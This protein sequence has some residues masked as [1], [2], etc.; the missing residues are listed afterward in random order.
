M[1]F[2]L[3]VSV[4]SLTCNKC[5]YGLAGFCLSNSEVTCENQSVCFTA[6][7]SKSPSTCLKAH[8][9]SFQTLHNSTVMIRLKSLP[10][11]VTPSHTHIDQQAHPVFP[12]TKSVSHLT[13]YPCFILSLIQCSNPFVYFSCTECIK[14]CIY[15]VFLK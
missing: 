9:L 10:N 14:S 15:A 6:K 13:R 12:G 5:S 3:C 2:P 1:R 4:D 8:T 11:T 7:T